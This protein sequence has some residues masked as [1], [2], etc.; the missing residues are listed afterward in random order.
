MHDCS[1]KK[2]TLSDYELQLAKAEMM[3]AKLEKLEIESY[4]ELKK[5]KCRY[6]LENH[7]GIVERDFF[8]ELS[9]MGRGTKRRWSSL[10]AK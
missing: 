8:A 3:M 7:Q 2:S 1:G 9:K 6:A 10:M 4:G 5:A